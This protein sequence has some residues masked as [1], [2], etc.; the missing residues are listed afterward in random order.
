[1]YTSFS[2]AAVFSY[3]SSL[4]YVLILD[5]GFDTRQASLGLLSLMVGYFCAIVLFVVLEKA[6]ISSEEKSPSKVLQPEKRLYAGVIGGLLMCLA[7][8]W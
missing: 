1:V 2:Y 3:F 6:V 7:E 5:Y 4:Q 8:I